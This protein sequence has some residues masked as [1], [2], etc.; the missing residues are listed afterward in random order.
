MS[1]PD[2][3]KRLDRLEGYLQQDPG[4]PQ[5]LADT[6]DAA[7]RAAAWDRAEF[8]LRHAQVLGHDRPA[9]TLREA[10]WLLGQHR[11]AEAR[12]ALLALQAEMHDDPVR[13]AI[14]VADLAYVDLR[15]GELAAGIA[16]LE[17]WLDQP[18]G[19]AL[20]EPALEPP[21]LRL[22]H[23]DG[24]IERAMAWLQRR[25]QAG[26]LSAT[27][28]GVASLIALDHGAY[29]DSLRWAEVALA[30]AE[31][32]LEALVARA[33]LALSEQN[34]GLARRLLHVAMARNDRDGR[35]WSALGFAELLEQ[36][37]PA[38]R[39][40]FERAVVLMER[41]VGTW[42][43]L[44]WTALAQG[45]LPGA[46]RAFAEALERDRNFAESHGGAAVVS[47]LEGDAD[48]ARRQIEVALRLDR[49]CL[50][51]RY[52]EAVL[53]GDARDTQSLLR[54]A[55]RLLA[56]RRVP[57]GGEVVDLLRKQPAGGPTRSP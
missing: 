29:E 4:N 5:L 32:P 53:G 23:L 27:S 50:S 45:D 55:D 11:W 47:A 38:A 34:P 33:S 43:G 3:L 28:A 7:L 22:L 40:A 26:P 48:A 37:L 42:H 14:V 25:E 31:P 54:L 49:H 51:A 15:L 39:A 12:E 44:G 30:E 18:D 57:L 16:R 9:W 8:H 2:V 36:K 35:I 6:F 56:G 24:Q 17:P 52:A 13:A 10:H 20:P 46:R 1:E 41:H 19:A 21:W